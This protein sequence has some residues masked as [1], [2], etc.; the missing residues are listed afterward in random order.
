MWAPWYAVLPLGPYLKWQ[1]KKI[2]ISLITLVMDP[3][4]R[5]HIGPVGTSIVHVQIEQCVLV[6]RFSNTFSM[7]K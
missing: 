3:G 4:G 6:M 7:L 5:P 2:I 1:K